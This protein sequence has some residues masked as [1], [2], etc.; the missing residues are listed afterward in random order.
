MSTISAIRVQ[1]EDRARFLQE[2][3]ARLSAELEK[4]RRELDELTMYRTW[5][6]SNTP[7]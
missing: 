7:N 2:E 6:D 3:L 4:V 1:L 5:L